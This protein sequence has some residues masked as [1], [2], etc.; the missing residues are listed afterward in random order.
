MVKPSHANVTQGLSLAGS[1]T[2][3]NLQHGHGVL[4]VDCFVAS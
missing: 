1:L 4:L 2:P 3:L